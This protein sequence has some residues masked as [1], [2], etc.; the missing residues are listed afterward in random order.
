MKKRIG[1][2]AIAISW[3]TLGWVAFS[4]AQVE[5]PPKP[6]T[7]TVKVVPGE[8]YEA[9]GFRRFVMGDNYRD[10]WTTAITVPVLD[11]RGYAG[12]LTP[13]K[14]GGSKQTKSL[15]FLNRDGY[16]FVF[17]LVDKDRL[18]TP[19]GFE[20]SLIESA[21]RD[22]VSTH[23]PAGAIVA[24]VFLTAAGVLHPSPMLAVMPDDSLLGKFREEFAGKLGQIEAYPNVPAPP[25]AIAFADRS[26]HVTMQTTPEGFGGAIEIIES[27]S[28]LTL[29]NAN[30]AERV[31]A[32]AFLTA[33]LVDHYI[34]DWD[35]HDGNWK[36]ARLE[37]GGMWIPIARDRDKA[38]ISYGGLPA[39][40]KPVATQLVRFQAKYPSMR[41]LTWHS[42]DLDRRLLAGLHH[43]VYDS[44]A[45]E[46]GSRF[47]DALIDSALHTM[48]RE[49]YFTIPEMSAK[50]KS[51]RDL[52]NVQ[53]TEFYQYMCKM[54]DV[55]ATD[56]ADSA[57][58]TIADDHVDLEICTESG[59]PYYTRRFKQH[60]TQEVRV[61]LHGG[62][63]RAIVRGNAKAPVEVRVIGGNGN[64]HLVDAA[65]AVKHSDEVRF[66]D[67]GETYNVSYGPTVRFDRRPWI[68]VGKSLANPKSDWAARYTPVIG[69]DISG[70][71]GFEPTL[72]WQRTSYD[73]G[74]HPYDNKWSLAGQYSSRADGFRVL[75]YF[76]KHRELSP[77]KAGVRA[78]WSEYEVISFHG[79]GNDTPASAPEEFYRVHQD[80][81]MVSPVVGWALG[82]RTDV[83]LGPIVKYS[84]T[85]STGTN[86]ISET[87]PYGSGDFRQAGLQLALHKDTRERPRD[88]YRG[89][90]LDLS[91]TVYPQIWDVN[92]TFGVLS[93]VSAAYVTV[94]FL[95]RP[96][97]SLKAGAKQVLG[98]EFP[99]HEA[100]FAGGR[101]SQR[102]LDLERYAG[103]AAVYGSVE[104]R[105]PVIGFT[106]LM[107]IDTG[108][109]VYGD[110][111]RVYVDRKSPGGW[112]D[113][114]GVGF[115]FGLL[116]PFSGI[117]FEFGGDPGRNLVQAKFGFTY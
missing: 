66:Y 86:F 105:I 9:G 22:Q 12:G 115:W 117:N 68:P 96:F 28:L 11:L 80:Q 4:F 5:P 104:L 30:P 37:P 65:G 56:A 14:I 108:V 77:L 23:H 73:F 85:D 95:T 114:T 74:K 116:N 71:Y 75:G 97:F 42:I 87:R 52:L 109:F 46:L 93:A 20:K 89:V 41:G 54:V 91:A 99:F 29:M 27:D 48:P 111:T 7:L 43:E 38:L 45:T 79:Y 16:E 64:N 57:T 92:S 70:D 44:V 88:K 6:G 18:A 103:D 2:H 78:Y 53:A 10:L 102:E 33:R 110:A 34:N 24:D 51:R 72:G 36:W 84:T 76:D 90:L 40:L 3:L 8:R 112:H 21:L 26:G 61:Y 81:W 98:D 47:T 39:Q 13:T 15:R 35:R 67:E 101:P 25:E 60:E 62:D 1:T 106:F 100:A 113:A 83:T 49:Y 69:F 17:R 63:D 55:H 32:R 94:P 19:E 31:D 82:R 58:V 59:A 50:L 107:P